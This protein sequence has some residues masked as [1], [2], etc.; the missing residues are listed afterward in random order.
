MRIWQRLRYWWDA[1]ADEPTQ[2]SPRPAIY[3]F[4][5][6]DYRRYG[7]VRLLRGIGGF[8]LRHWQ[9]LWGSVIA[10]ILAVYF[11]H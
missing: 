6:G 2:P 1:R 5:A 8:Y 7:V 3:E 9:W 11:G 4:Y 10:I